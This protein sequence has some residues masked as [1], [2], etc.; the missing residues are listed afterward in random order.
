MC[1]RE[2]SF[3]PVLLAALL[4]GNAVSAQDNQF[5]AP[6]QF[7][8]PVNRTRPISD[9]DTTGNSEPTSEIVD[10]PG[11]QLASRPGPL[12]ADA[13][14]TDEAGVRYRD[15]FRDRQAPF[16]S[17][18]Q[19]ELDSPLTGSYTGEFG[20]E[21]S[22]TGFRN[23]VRLR[24]PI[25]FEGTQS[26]RSSFDIMGV[27]I[28]AGISGRHGFNLLGRGFE[29]Q[30]ADLK[31]GP[32]FFKLRALSGS[33]LISDNANQDE[34]D[35]ES[36][37]IAIVRLAGSVVAQ[38]TESLRLSASANI[39]YLPFEGK[40]GITADSGYFDFDLTGRGA[41]VPLAQIDW[42][43]KIGE[44]DVFVSD[45][46]Y[47]RLS[48][49]T[50]NYLYTESLFEGPSFD[51]YDTLG[52]YSYGGYGS[53]RVR[54][55]PLTN[56]DRE[57]GY[58]TESFT[59][60]ID[61]GAERL[62]PGPI[63]LRLRA[64]R[65][66]YWYNQGSRGGPSLRE[67]ASA[68]LRVERPNMRFQPYVRYE[69]SHT[70]V[71]PEWDQYIIGGIRGPITDQLQLNLYAGQF[72][73][74]QNGREAFLAGL[75]LSHIAGPYTYQTL[76]VGRE[77]DDYFGRSEVG[78]RISYRF[79]Q[80]LGPKIFADLFTSYIRTTTLDDSGDERREFDAGIRLTVL[81]GPRTRA[82]LSYIYSRISA[83]SPSFVFSGEDRLDDDDDDFDDDD[84][85]GFDRDREFGDRDSLYIERRLRLD[86]SY[87]FTDTLTG[88]LTYE[89][90]DVDST[91]DS[92]SFRENLVILTLS[93]YF[94]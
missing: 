58:E 20:Y 18:G 29:P 33:L 62:F 61:V 53:R 25:P 57:D 77:V 22:V 79:H 73:E 32:L 34:E 85:D 44:W 56:T 10:D 60:V 6:N 41:G 68:L 27:R 36:G 84:D 48:D 63:R 35:P 69:I 94:Y 15:L 39:I 59:N 76:F 40:V 23:D 11:G 24:E 75:Q 46:F 70:D 93:K 71:E 74:G 4:L 54:D 19:A 45:S 50:Q 78:D 12:P 67:G 82:R 17:S 64:H 81:P 49:I 83:S 52:R 13:F 86:V 92:E 72:I 87:R 21:G 89:N 80:I 5:D 43:G 16:R 14:R 91:I 1:R 65:E 26:I 30:D 37:A 47:A 3:A 90:R 38:L 55:V 31:V 8:Q 9:G 28:G 2:G 51:E 66:D 88:Y 7:E 42:E